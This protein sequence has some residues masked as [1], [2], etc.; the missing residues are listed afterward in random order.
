VPISDEQ[1]AAADAANFELL[2]EAVAREGF[3]FVTNPDN[4]VKSLTEDEL[5][6][7]YAGEITNWAEVGGDNAPIYAYQRNLDSGSQTY[8]NRF[9]GETAMTTPP[10]EW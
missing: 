1:Q 5:R 9:M 6:G 7:I 2:K 8:M 3:V 10:T 4:P